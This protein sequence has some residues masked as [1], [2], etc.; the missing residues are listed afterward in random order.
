MTAGASEPFEQAALRHVAVA[1]PADARQRL[2]LRELLVLKGVLTPAQLESALAE[3][4]RS[5]RRLGRI[6]LEDGIG[7]E[8]AI[9][10]ALAVQ[11][12]PL[13]GRVRPRVGGKP[14]RCCAHPDQ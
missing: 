5:G 13:D 4:K 11:A 6:L 14:L 3:R 7:S 10:Q 12:S 2:R 8:E 1:K 9:A